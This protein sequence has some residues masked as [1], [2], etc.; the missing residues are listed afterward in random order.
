MRRYG[1]AVG[2]VIAAMVYSA[3]SHAANIR[4][5]EGRVFEG[6]IIGETADSVRVREKTGEGQYIETEYNRSEIESMG[7]TGRITGDEIVAG[8][9]SQLSPPEPDAG[10]EEADPVY[11]DALDGLIGKIEGL[12]VIWDIDHTRFDSIKEWVKG[13]EPLKEAFQQRYAGSGRSSYYYISMALVELSNFMDSVKNFEKS[14]K[15]RQDME[16][17]GSYG[18]ADKFRD[19]AKEYEDSASKEISKTIEY[20]N[21]ARQRAVRQ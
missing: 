9:I 21:I 4:L 17:N 11:N 19:V 14:R 16:R 2:I 8:I 15:S 5:K 10:P 12:K 1:V 6:E 13:F 7:N 20:C 18:L 3:F